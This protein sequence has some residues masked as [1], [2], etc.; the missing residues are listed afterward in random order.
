MCLSF[1]LHCEISPALT[2]SLTF[3]VPVHNIKCP[4]PFSTFKTEIQEPRYLGNLNLNSK[5]FIYSISKLNE[6]YTSQHSKKIKATKSI[7]A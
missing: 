3:V 6:V 2:A 5:K 7:N 1:Q 4:L